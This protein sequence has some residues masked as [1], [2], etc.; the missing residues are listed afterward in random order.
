VL[1][2]PAVLQNGGAE[3]GHGD[4]LP[5]RLVGEEPLHVGALDRPL[6]G[7]GVAL[8]DV[9]IDAERGVLDGLQDPAEPLPKVDPAQEDVVVHQAVGQELLDQLP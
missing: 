1:D 6:P 9:L 5:G 3:S 4:L 8:E 7:D 2:N